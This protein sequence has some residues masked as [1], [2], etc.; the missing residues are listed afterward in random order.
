MKIN[1]V[2]FGKHC[3]VKWSLAHKFSQL[4]WNQ[5]KLSQ[6]LNLCLLL[7]TSVKK[8]FKKKR[9]EELWRLSENS[10]FMSHGTSLFW[11]GVTWFAESILDRALEFLLL[12]EKKRAVLAIHQLPHQ[13]SWILQLFLA[14]SCK[15]IDSVMGLRSL[16]SCVIVEGVMQVHP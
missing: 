13:A 5:I 1:S 11:G 12:L 8:A 14:Y 3:Y 10:L 16:L 2:H 15:K 6:F 4:I 9:K 7:A